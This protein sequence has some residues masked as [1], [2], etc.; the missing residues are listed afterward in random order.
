MINNNKHY[1]LLLLHLL[2]FS[3]VFYLSIFFTSGI[4]V[5]MTRISIWIFFFFLT[6]YMALLLLPLSRFS[7]VR[8]RATPQTAAH[9]A[10]LSLGF[11]GQEFWS[12]LPVPSPILHGS[13][14]IL[15]YM[16]CNLILI[17]MPIPA[18]FNCLP[19]LIIHY[20]FP[21]L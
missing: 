21:C 6:S 8:L 10:P 13:P 11:S 9:Q 20:I 7:R 18:S 2:I 16:E 15:K 14:Y 1:S 4:I 12:G 3:T 5:L 17:L 19:F